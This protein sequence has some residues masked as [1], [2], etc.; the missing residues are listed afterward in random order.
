MTGAEPQSPYDRVTHP[1]LIVVSGPSGVGKDAAIN[2]M[3]ELG[4]PLHFVIT[5]TT[6]PRRP[7]EVHGRDYFF[8]SEEEFARM[9]EQDELLEH[10]IVYGDHK[11]IPKRQVRQAMASGQDVIM[12]VD[13]QGAATVRRLVPEAVLIFLICSEEELALRLQRRKTET[14]E[15]LATRLALAR[16][17]MGRISE[18][19]YV[20]ANREGELDEAVRH[21][22]AIIT[23]EKCRVQQREIAL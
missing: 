19:D 14:P 20:V 6:R 2:R 5:A 13:V 7:N 9:L 23:A 11:G 10:A 3:K 1:L 18:F 21:I 17:E 16:Q 4:Y 8:L 22:A 15:S 12:R